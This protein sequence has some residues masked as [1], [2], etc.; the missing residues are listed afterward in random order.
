M[1][2]TTTSPAAATLRELDRR[3]T[4]GVEITLLWNRSDNCVIV[5]MRNPARGRTLQF[6]AD[7]RSARDA[8]SHPFAYATARGLPCAVILRAA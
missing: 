5:S 8:F 6:D 4:G 3:M 1:T 7:P 2:T